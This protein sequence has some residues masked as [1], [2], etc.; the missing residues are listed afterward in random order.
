MLSEAVAET[1]KDASLDSRHRIFDNRTNW[2]L[3]RAHWEDFILS[4][5]DRVG[6]KVRPIYRGR[7]PGRPVEFTR[8][9]LVVADRV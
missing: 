5:Y 4:V 9:D 7:W 2:F 1:V 3:Q 8:Q 6:L